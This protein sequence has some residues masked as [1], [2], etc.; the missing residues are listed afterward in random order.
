MG[1]LELNCVFLSTTEAYGNDELAPMNK[2]V[3]KLHG[4]IVYLYTSI[5]AILVNDQRKAALH[6][7]VQLNFKF[8]FLTGKYFVISTSR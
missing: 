6:I 8:P 2:F 1:V 3:C 7:D 5:L 4:Y